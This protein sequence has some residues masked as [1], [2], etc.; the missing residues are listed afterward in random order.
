MKDYKLTPHESE[1]FWS[2]V[3][4][5][6]TCWNWTRSVT[7][8]GGYGQFFVRSKIKINYMAHRLAYTLLRGPIP[9]GM[10][11]DHMCHNRRCVNPAHLRAVDH[12]GNAENH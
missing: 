2:K 5:T 10:Q 12:K 11:L 1:L 4:K 3:D 7:K 9:A 8:H 6:D